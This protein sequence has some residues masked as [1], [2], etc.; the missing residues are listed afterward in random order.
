[1]KATN[2]DLHRPEESG[3]LHSLFERRDPDL[4]GK[5]SSLI[6]LSLHQSDMV[7]VLPWTQT[8]TWAWPNRGH[9]VP[10]NPNVC[11]YRPTSVTAIDSKPDSRLALLV[12][13]NSFERH[14]QSLVS[15]RS[16]L[17]QYSV[18]KKTYDLQ[19]QICSQKSADYLI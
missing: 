1:M 8:I 13:V 7:L 15:K 12:F 10:R 14:W 2:V 11:G 18:G 17:T 3:G 9:G 16:I 6:I 4:G 19:A 5:Q